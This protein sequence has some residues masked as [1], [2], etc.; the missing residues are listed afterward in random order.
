MDQ[1]P[2]HPEP[3]PKPEDVPQPVTRG[4]Y[5]VVA[6]ERG[7][8]HGFAKANAKAS[9]K[10]N[11]NV[12]EGLTYA[13]PDEMTLERGDRVEVP[14]GR[15][16]TRV[17]GYIVELGGPELIAGGLDP[18]RIKPVA[19]RTGR[20]LSPG[21]VDL[22]R[23]I[24]RYYAAPLGLTLAAAMPAAVR[25]AVG[26][27]TQR[28][29]EPTDQ[30]T[31][32]PA[33]STESAGQKLTPSVRR[34]LE[35]IGQLPDSA[36]PLDARTLAA[37]VGA[38]NAA[39]I[40]R[41]TEAGYLREVEVETVRTRDT[42]DE[43]IAAA[44]AEQSQA[45]ELTEAQRAIVDGVRTDDGFSTHL[46]LGV[47]GSGKT[48]VYLRLIERV[49]DSGGSALVLVPEI[50]LT[51]QTSARF[52]SRFGDRGVAVL[53]SGLS[54]GRRHREWSRAAS[55]EARVV[56]GARSALFAPVRDLGLIVVDEEHDPSYK[57][58][59]SPRYHGRDAAIRRAQIEV[60]PILLGSAT[61][62]L[63]SYANAR[64]GRST[65][66]RLADRVAGGRLPRVEIVDMTRH[67]PEAGAPETESLSPALAGALRETLDAGAQAILLLNRRG[68]ASCVAC[69][70]PA[71]GWMLECDDCAARMVLHRAGLRPGQHAPRGFVRCHHCLA[72]KTI[73]E[74]CPVCARRTILLGTGTQKVEAQLSSSLGIGPGDLARVDSDTMRSARDYFD[75]L[76]R[77]AAGSPRVLLGTQMLAKGLDFPGVRLVGVISADT[78]LHLP[79]FRAAE[80]TFQLVAQVAGR[81]GRADE[82]GRVVVQTLDPGEAGIVRAAAHDYEGFALPE[83]RQ[84]RA[85]GLPP[86]ARMARVICRHE[87]PG[88][89]EAS[90]RTIAA[91]LRTDGV[92]VEGPMPCVLSRLSGKFRFEVRLTAAGPGPIQAALTRARADGT[93]TPG[94]LTAVDVDPVQFM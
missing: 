82:L 81:A 14:L 66:W 78:A 48:E 33:D 49:L 43:L 21:V 77:F 74:H 52:L 37:R 5:A 3:E 16:D 91:A 58:D 80:R 12:S 90:A 47:T 75:V 35:G 7:I 27:K 79:D 1:L 50:A 40:N 17:G 42:L 54:A 73:P 55:G 56:V 29:L 87:D 85:S 44:P 2:F 88:R 39:P 23:W 53:H 32:T 69:P 26:R 84:R 25:K 63:E 11:A 13:V 86:F 60:C 10:A 70:S 76:G 65:L 4:R 15:G 67:R 28:A 9:G 34:A 31:E 8:D 22:C 46:L 36:W 6:V 83:L 62:S 20:A 59:Q 30:A 68:F 89:A 71:C 41:L 64:T 45:P 19:A 94:D 24:A 61:P 38:P 92:R 72:E 51:P 93:L 18:S 57:Q